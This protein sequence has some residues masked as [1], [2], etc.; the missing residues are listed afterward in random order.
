MQKDMKLE[1]AVF[2][3]KNE[4]RETAREKRKGYL[5]HADGFGF[6]SNK[7]LRTGIYKIHN[8]CVKII[9]NYNGSDRR[10]MNKFVRNNYVPV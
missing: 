2:S 7:A 5:P 1:K 6:F 10:Q 8:P 3:L 4:K 9:W